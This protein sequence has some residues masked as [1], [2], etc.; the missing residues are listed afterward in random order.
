MWPLTF[1]P[2]NKVIESIEKLLDID[3]NK[4]NKN[5]LIPLTD[6]F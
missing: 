5:K 2:E 4:I 3:Y 6:Y 1:V